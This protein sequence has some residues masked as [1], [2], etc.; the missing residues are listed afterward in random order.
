MSSY[1]VTLREKCGISPVVIQQANREQGNIE[2]FKAGKSAFSIN[3]KFNNFLKKHFGFIKIYILLHRNINYNTMQITEKLFLELYEQGMK[4]SEIARIS[5][6]SPSTI[7]KLRKSK[8]LNVN[9]RKIVEDEI[10]LDLYN[11]GKIDPEIAQITGASITQVKRRRDKFGLAP[12]V[13][14]HPL[15]DCFLELYNLGNNDLDISKIT[16]ISK[17]VVQNYRIKLNLPPIGKHTIDDEIVEKL[18]KQGYN[19]E[20]IG[21]KLNRA[22][23]TIAKHRQKLRLID[24]SKIPNNYKYSNEEFQVILGSLLG[25]GSLVKTHVNGGTILKI[26]HCEQQKQ[27]LEY[28]WNLLKNNS[29]EIKHYSFTDSRRKIP[30]YKQYSFYTKSSL[31]LNDTYYNWYRPIKTIYKEDLF[32]LEP[33]GLAI[34]YMDDGYKCNPYGGCMLCTNNFSKNELELIKEMFSS[35][36]NINVTLNNKANNLVYIP[37]SEFSKFKDLIKP[38]VI[39]TMQ[40]KL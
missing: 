37:S 34:W 30:E 40:Y 26:S 5:G 13:K 25:D 21:K 6:D 19:D 36:F 10:I 29:S 9:G 32:K 33:L 18:V 12:N 35:K 22:P 27:Y 8:G 28:K 16:G 15:D 4:D 31:S 1:L 38:Y 17:S 11:K 14:K 24:F 39:P 7:A 20:Q 23:A 2:R 3:D